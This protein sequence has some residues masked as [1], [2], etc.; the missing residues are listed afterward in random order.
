MLSFIRLAAG[1]ALTI[2]L[3]VTGP[4]TAASFKADQKGEIEQIVRDYLLANPEVIRDAMQELER[5][6][7][8]EERLAAE[9]AVADSS[10]VLFNS[11]RQVELGNPKGDVTLVEFFD[12]NCGYC[13]RSLLDMLRLIN[14]DKNLRV[15]LKEFPVLGQPSVEAAQVS[16]AANIVDPSKYSDFHQ[17]LLQGRNRANKASALQIA[18][19]AGYDIAEVEKAMEQPEV[20]ATI[21]EVYELANRLSLTGTPSF[22][23]GNEVVMG[24]VGYDSLKQKIAAIRDCGT[25]TC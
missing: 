6:Q 19:K 24:A 25:A 23:V 18:G 13:K 21:E 2:C 16:I 1:L 17:Q 9:Q 8:E 7:A 3:L 15:V 4:A 14:E 11:T 12:Y 22:V 10:G 5:R 20:I